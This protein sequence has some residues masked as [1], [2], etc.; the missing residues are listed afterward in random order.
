[1]SDANELLAANTAYYR[2]FASGD[3]AAMSRIWADEGVSC[4]HPGWPAL[5]GRA[6]ILKSY[7][8]ILSGMNRVRIAH[9]DDTVIV[10]GGDGRVLCV[11][12]VEGAALAATNCYRRVDGVWRMVHHQ[13]SPIAAPPEQ[14]ETPPRGRRLN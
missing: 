9:R 2:A 14:S 6:A 7:R 12:I 8:G 5:I 13:A 10:M 11:E 1:M 3:V 4:V